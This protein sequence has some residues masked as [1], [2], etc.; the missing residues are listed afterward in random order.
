TDEEHGAGHPAPEDDQVSRLPV[1]RPRFR[2]G[3]IQWGFAELR[4][5]FRIHVV[6]SLGVSR[7]RGR[8][9]VRGTPRHLAITTRGDR[10]PGTP[11]WQPWTHPP[12]VRAGIVRAMPPT[13]T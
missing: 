12:A 5:R 10:A 6:A 3:R 9:A 7:A 8:D 1:R 11:P 4:D 2:P 13:E